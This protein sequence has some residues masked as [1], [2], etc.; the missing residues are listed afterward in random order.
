MCRGPL[1]PRGT[2]PIL[3]CLEPLDDKAVCSAMS[4]DLSL[5][6]ISCGDDS[7][8]AQKFLVEISA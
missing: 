2:E 8:G 5:P 3:L 1:R 6:G 4:A 7:C